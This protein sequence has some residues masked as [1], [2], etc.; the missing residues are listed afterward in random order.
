MTAGFDNVGLPP[1]RGD[2]GDSVTTL[3][4]ELQRE[5]RAGTSRPRVLAR[6]QE[7]ARV[8]VDAS[9]GDASESDLRDAARA[10]QADIAGVSGLERLQRALREL[11][12]SGGLSS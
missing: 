1:P 7:V 3:I 12:G 10:A 4:A 2:G 6:V 8:A 9:L 5:V 11:E